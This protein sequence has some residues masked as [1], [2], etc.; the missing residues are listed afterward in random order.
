MLGGEANPRG[1]VADV[2]QIVTRRS[3][4]EYGNGR[5]SVASTR[6]KIALLAPMP[7]ASVAAATIVKAGALRSW[8]Q[9]ND[10]SCRSS[11]IMAALPEKLRR[12]DARFGS[13]GSSMC[14]ESSILLH[15]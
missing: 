11:S 15:T 10:T 2:S 8:R 4:S 13:L 9:A 14:Y 5:S 3:G 12:D 1:V 7:S 6:A